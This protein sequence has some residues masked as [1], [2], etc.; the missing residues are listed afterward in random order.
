[1]DTMKV[2][3]RY[4]CSAVIA[5]FLTVP[6]F[7]QDLG[8]NQYELNYTFKVDPEQDQTSVTIGVGEKAHRLVELRLRIDPNHHRDFAGDG[9]LTLSDD[10]VVWRPPK[11]GGEITYTVPITHKR[12]NG[13]YDAYVADDWAIFRGDDFVPPISVRSKLNAESLAKLYFELPKGWSAVT[14]FRPSRFGGFNVVDKRRRF[15]RP[16]GWMLV[17][18]FGQRIDE[19]DGVRV[20]IAAPKNQGFHRMDV[21]AFLQWNLPELIKVF[22]NYSNR[23]LILGAGDPM[24]RGGLSGPGSLFL[25]ASRPLI[26]ENGTSTLLHE[27]VHTAMS[28]S[29]VDDDWIVEGFAEFYSVE[30]MRRSGTLSKTRYSKTSRDLRRWGKDVK[31]LRSKNSQ[32]PVTARA[33]GIFRKLDREIR[34]VT[35]NEYSLDDVASRLAKNGRIDL[36]HLR[37]VAEE[38]MDKESEAL[39]SD[40]LPGIE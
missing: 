13:A 30:L 17:G 3:S 4:S 14:P 34:K 10:S 20:V 23:L 37:S 6:A 12:Q 8:P 33:V 35:D 11:D 1:M 28:I 39:S 31:D 36:D 18:E 38:L 7:S 19:I 21:L 26:S 29:S 22:P 16:T 2:F 15:D 32:G 5:L 27:L 9:E 24:W 25:H 40:N